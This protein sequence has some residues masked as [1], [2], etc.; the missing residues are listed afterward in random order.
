MDGIIL[1]IELI[2]AKLINNKVNISDWEQSFQML[3]FY[4][5]DLFGLLLGNFKIL[6]VIGRKYGVFDHATINILSYK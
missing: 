2:N 6:H 1:L 4:P 5:I 3:I